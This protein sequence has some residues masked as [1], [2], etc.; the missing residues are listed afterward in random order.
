[1]R[2]ILLGAALGLSTLS[3]AQVNFSS[4]RFGITAGG[5]YSGVSNAHSP[6]GKRMSLFGGFLAMIPVD[7]NNQF[8]IQPEVEYLGA[9]ETGKD[10]DYK[11]RANSGY[12]AVYA[13]NYISVPVFFKG[14]FSEAESEFFGLLG[15]TFNFLINQKVSNNTNPYYTVDGVNVVN[16]ATGQTVNVN[17][18]ASSFNF[19]IGAG[20]GY[21]YK[22]KLEATLRYNAGL[23]N[24]YKNLTSDAKADAN[25]AKRKNTQVISAGLS[26]IFD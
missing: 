19:G 10:K 21:S 25:L 5:T 2:K 9:G 20:V 8:F 16:P 3:F 24:T 15:P 17:G 7:N 4:M 11:N 12:D 26:Y 22:R 18:K 23:S 13:D 6:S 14:Y 1:M